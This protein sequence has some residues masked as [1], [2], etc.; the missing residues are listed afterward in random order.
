MDSRFNRLTC[1]ILLKERA[2]SILSLPAPY[3]IRLGKDSRASYIHIKSS[4][5]YAQQERSA[6]ALLLLIGH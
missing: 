4:R 1:A 2:L 5:S 6:T 3:P